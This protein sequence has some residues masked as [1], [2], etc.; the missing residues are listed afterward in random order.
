[1]QDQEIYVDLN[2]EVVGRVERSLGE[3]TEACT[4]CGM[5]ADTRDHVIPRA[6]R[7][8]VA[9]DVLLRVPDTVPCCREC[10]SLAGDRI[11]CE[12]VAEKREEI[13]FLLRLRYR[14]LLALPD[15]GSEELAEL[16]PAMRRSVRAR[17]RERDTVLE[18][19]AWPYH[20]SMKYLERHDEALEQS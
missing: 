17:L 2:G 3:A 14:R 19:L 16:G 15:W 18:R 5:P 7:G 8:A 1:M 10:N 12:S 20:L 6:A 13:Q 4:Y 9:P 11:V